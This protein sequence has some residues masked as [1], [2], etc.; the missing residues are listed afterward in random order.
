[1]AVGKPLDLTQQYKQN[2]YSITL[3]MSG[4]DKTTFQVI[5][6]VVGTMYVY[7]SN[8]GGA[9]QSQTQGNATLATNFATIQAKKL[10]D[11]TSVTSV[12]A[13]GLYEVDVNAQYLRL[14]GGG[15]NVYGLMFFHSK[16]G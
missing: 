11:G 13:A 9:V 8:N 16:L 1:M 3:D 12:N 10:S 7:G 4:W 14:Q 2:I 15:A 5:A 6:P